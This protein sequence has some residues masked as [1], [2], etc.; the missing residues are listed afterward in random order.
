[1]EDDARLVL[2][3][4]AARA[5]AAAVLPPAAQGKAPPELAGEGRSVPPQVADEV[6]PVLVAHYKEKPE[7]LLKVANAIKNRQP[8][9][10]MDAKPRAALQDAIARFGFF[11]YLDWKATR[12]ARLTLPKMRKPITLGYTATLIYWAAEALLV[13]FAAAAVM[14]L[15]SRSPYCTA[16][17]RWKES[18]ELGRLVLPRDRALEVFGSGAIVALAGEN[19]LNPDGPLRVTVLSCPQCATEAPIEV[20]L[21]EVSKNDKD[22]DTVTELVQLTYPGPAL[23]VLEALFVVPEKPPDKAENKTDNPEGEAEA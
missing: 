8:P 4:R 15:Y 7:A 13:G 23:R 5:L 21:A 11:D 12:G 6:V 14:V 17:D 1:M 2:P 18:R 16:C 20:K 19:L 3:V 9:P 22:K 10:E